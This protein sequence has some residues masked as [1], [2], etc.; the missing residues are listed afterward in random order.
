MVTAK[1]STKSG[2]LLNRCLLNRSTTV[3]N[4]V[5]DQ[6]CIFPAASIMPQSRRHKYT[7]PKISEEDEKFVVRSPY[8]DVEIPECNMADFVWKNVEQ[9]PEHVALVKDIQSAIDE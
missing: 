5:R 3:V 8:P 7:Y 4:C 2:F 9:W 1:F 6:T